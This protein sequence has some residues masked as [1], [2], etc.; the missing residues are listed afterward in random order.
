MK[1]ATPTLED[2]GVALRQALSELRQL[3]LGGRQQSQDAPR[4]GFLVIRAA[5]RGLHGLHDCDCGVET[6]KILLVNT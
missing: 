1:S 4:D 2:L 6:N 3:L 5:T